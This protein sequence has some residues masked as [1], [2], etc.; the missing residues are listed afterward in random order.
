MQHLQY[1]IKSL[2]KFT[3]ALPWLLLRSILRCIILLVPSLS[4]TTPSSPSDCPRLRFSSSE[5][6]S[7]FISASIL[8]HCVSDTGS[9]WAGHPLPWNKPHR[10]NGDCLE[11]KGENYQVWS[12][13]YCVQQLCT[14]QCTHKRT[15]L[16][17]L[18]IGFCLTGPI[19]LC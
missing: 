1:G 2:S 11:G 4:A 17:V 6:Q 14:V 19:S 8:L 15:H 12:V 9:L 16:R 5:W 13:Q 18:W 3:V 7:V 10:S